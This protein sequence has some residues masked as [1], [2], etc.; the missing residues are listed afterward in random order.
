VS[1]AA[2]AGVQ[3]EQHAQVA[4]SLEKLLQAWS[5]GVAEYLRTERRE[6]IEREASA[7]TLEDLRLTCKWLLRLSNL[8]EALAADPEF[9]AARFWKQNHHRVWQLRES[10]AMLNN[11]L[12]ANQAE[13]LLQKYFPDEP[14]TGEPSQKT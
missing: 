14:Q 3:A 7:K 13:V 4:S 6:I 5:D 10:W 12:T 8:V 11:P 9:P 2:T 1:T